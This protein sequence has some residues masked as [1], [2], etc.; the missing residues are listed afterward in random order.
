MTLKSKRAKACDIPVKV[1][2]AVWERDCHCCIIC[3]RSEAMPNAHYIP[4]A[5]GGL[6][7]VQN[8]VTL[9]AKCHWRYDQSSDRKLF[10][11][12]IREYLMSKHPNWEEENLVYKK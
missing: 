7:I 6:G 9:C 8:I 11:G 4:R 10:K 3:G 2:E 12:A 1:K 5:Q